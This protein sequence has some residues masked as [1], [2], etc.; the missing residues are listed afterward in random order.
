LQRKRGWLFL[1]QHRR[2]VNREAGYVVEHSRRDAI[3]QLRLAAANAGRQK[4]GKANQDSENAARFHGRFQKVLI[5]S[6]PDFNRQWCFWQ[7]ALEIIRRC[8]LWVLK[9]QRQKRLREWSFSQG[10][11]RMVFL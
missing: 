4:A 7:D 9:S 2:I 3:G 1:F 8:G 11:F 5:H 6:A 10:M